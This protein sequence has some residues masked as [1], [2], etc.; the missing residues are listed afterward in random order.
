MR[1][2]LACLRRIKRRLRQVADVQ[3]TKA[4]MDAARERISAIETRL[5]TIDSKV[6]TGAVFEIVLKDPVKL[7]L[8]SPISEI[9]VTKVRVL[10]SG[11]VVHTSPT[12]ETTMEEDTKGKWLFLRPLLLQCSQHKEWL[13]VSR[14][15]MSNLLIVVHQNNVSAMFRC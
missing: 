1:R 4:E 15:M 3:A 13:D 10:K 6:G 2:L 5:T 7:T 9:D 12:D 11:I 8:V 14:S